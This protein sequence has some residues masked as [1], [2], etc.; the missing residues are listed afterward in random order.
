MKAGQARTLVD[1]QVLHEMGLTSAIGRVLGG[2][3][4]EVRPL[5]AEL[6]TLR[7]QRTAVLAYADELDASARLGGYR[8]STLAERLRAIMGGDAG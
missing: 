4:Q 3:E 2:I 7:A 8:R 5:L 1:E 6:E